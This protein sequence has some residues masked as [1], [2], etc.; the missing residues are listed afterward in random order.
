LPTLTRDVAERLWAKIEKRGIDECW[1][2]IAKA[3]SQGY[4]RVKIDGQCYMAHRVV[5]EFETR[6]TL[7]ENIGAGVSKNMILIRHSCNNRLC[8]NP[9]HLFEGTPKEVVQ[10]AIERGVFHF[11]DHPRLEEHGRLCMYK[12]GCKCELCRAANAKARRER[13]ARAKQRAVSVV[14]EEEEVG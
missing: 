14:A 9:K 13:R 7:P 10:D 1:P 6:N 2:W 11:A 8:C 5:Y 12:H 4:G 3:R